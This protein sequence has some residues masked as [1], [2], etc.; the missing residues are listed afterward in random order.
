MGVTF[1]FTKSLNSLKNC[2]LFIMKLYHINLLGLE[3]IGIFLSTAVPYYKRHTVYMCYYICM[4][5]K[6]QQYITLIDR[7]WKGKEWFSPF[8]SY[9]PTRMLTDSE[10]ALLEHIRLVEPRQPFTHCVGNSDGRMFC[11]TCGSQDGFSIY[12]MHRGAQR[13]W[14]TISTCVECRAREKRFL[15]K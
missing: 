3:G 2:F 8:G 15:S 12:K 10:A 1:C 9:R 11:M 5:E 4:N 7:T 6:K 14:Y 13:N